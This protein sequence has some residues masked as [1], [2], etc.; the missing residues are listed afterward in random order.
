MHRQR[1]KCIFQSE[2]P[3]LRQKTTESRSIIKKSEVAY[4]SLKLDNLIKPPV[5]KMALHLYLR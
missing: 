4:Y 1:I 2:I 5:L 3:Y